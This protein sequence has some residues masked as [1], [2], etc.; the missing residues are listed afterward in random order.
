MLHIHILL[1]YLYNEKDY[2]KTIHIL[3]DNQEKMFINYAN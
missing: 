3:T 2:Y 1:E